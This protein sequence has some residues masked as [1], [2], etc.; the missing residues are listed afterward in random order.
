MTRTEKPA[1]EDDLLAF[2]LPVE[3]PGHEYFYGCSGAPIID[4]EGHVVA[5][6]CKGDMETSTVYGISL[7]R[8]QVALDIHVGRFP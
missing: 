3:H 6:V 1:A 2:H 5:L 8:Y 4:A 7:R